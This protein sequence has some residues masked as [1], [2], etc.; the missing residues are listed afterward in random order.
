MWNVLLALALLRFVSGQV[1]A[2][3]RLP[4]LFPEFDVSFFFLAVVG[5]TLNC[6]PS[7]ITPKSLDAWHVVTHVIWNASIL[8]AR[9]IDV[10]DVILFTFATR[11][12]FLVLAK[13]TWCF[14]LCALVTCSNMGFMALRQGE[15]RLADGQDSLFVILYVMFIAVFVARRMLQDNAKLILDLKG[16][17]VELGRSLL[18]FFA[19]EDHT[20]ISEQFQSSIASESTAVMGLNADM[21]DSDQNHVKVELFHAQF[22]NL[23]NKTS[24]LV[25][26][27][28]I[29]G[30]ETAEPISPASP[31]VASCPAIGAR[32]AFWVVFDIPSFDILVLSEDLESFARAVWT[33]LQR[34][35]WTSP[36]HHLAMAFVISCSFWQ[37]GP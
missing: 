31:S 13:R 26:V 35:S 6:K 24:F 8:V 34:V 10:R 18:D 4:R 17:T 25:G 12:M 20:R 15:A 11:F 29:Q 1:L 7:L 21:L 9:E 5:L 32:G 23:A 27:R 37:T 22:Q 30:G 33:R 14:L 2:A 3:L 19:K 36:V 16:R 28:E